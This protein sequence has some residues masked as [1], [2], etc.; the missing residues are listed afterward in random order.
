[1]GP[2]PGKA[3]GT[4]FPRHPAERLLRAFEG[5]AHPDVDNIPQIEK[6]RAD[7]KKLSTITRAIRLYPRP[8]ASNWCRRSP[9]SSA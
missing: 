7:L 3:A 5:S 8:V 4:R 2:V 1:V 6:I 9:P